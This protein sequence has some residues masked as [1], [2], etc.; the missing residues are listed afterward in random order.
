MIIFYTSIIHYAQLCF[1]EVIFIFC[2]VFLDVYVIRR[3]LPYFTINYRPTR[4][5]CRIPFPC[6]PPKGF[7]KQKIPGKGIIHPL[8]GHSHAQQHLIYST[9]VI[10][11]P[12]IPLRRPIQSANL[13]HPESPGLQH[14]PALPVQVHTVYF[15]PQLLGLA[16]CGGTY[17]GKQR[18]ASRP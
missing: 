13:G 12:A 15:V 16:D 6:P 5:F 14:V 7:F 18:P 4:L 17:R 9:S 11:Q 8:P 10:H 3:Y 2:G 1:N